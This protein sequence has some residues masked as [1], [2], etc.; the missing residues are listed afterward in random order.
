MNGSGGVN[1]GVPV[2][3]EFGRR[4]CMSEDSMQRQD[5]GQHSRQDK[6]PSGGFD[7]EAHPALLG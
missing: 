3:T 2:N 4:F 5:V 7:L 1:A 6:T